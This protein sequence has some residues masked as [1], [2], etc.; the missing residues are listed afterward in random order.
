[1]LGS[2]DRPNAGQPA[3]KLYEIATGMPREMEVED[4]TWIETEDLDQLAEPPNGPEARPLALRHRVNLHACLGERLPERLNLI[5]RRA[6]S[7]DRVPTLYESPSEEQDV[8]L[9]AAHVRTI[10]EQDDWRGRRCSH[11]P[12]L[13]C[14]V[15]ACHVLTVV[16][17]LRRPESWP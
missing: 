11:A 14:A 2:D 4:G 6:D 9:H 12:T 10:G 15:V 13:G 1:V 17:Q 8:L 16:R 5:A 7:G 3:C